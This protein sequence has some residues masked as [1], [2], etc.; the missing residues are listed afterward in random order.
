M[1]PDR[2]TVSRFVGA[3]IIALVPAAGL[4][5]AAPEPQPPSSDEVRP[6]D[7]A[8]RELVEQL[9]ADTRQARQQASEK[10]LAAGSRAIHPLVAALPRASAETTLRGLAILKK[11]LQS[12]D[13][14]TKGKA[15]VALEQL[16]RS[17]ERS[18]AT[19]AASILKAQDPLTRS[20]IRPPGQV[21]GIPGAFRMFQVQM[22]N[23]PATRGV[24]AR[25]NRQ[26]VVIA[27]SR[28]KGISVTVSE[29]VNGKE[30]TTTVVAESS[31]ELDR[32]S[33]QAAALYRK[34]MVRAGLG[35]PGGNPLIAP[36]MVI[37]AEPFRKFEMRRTAPPAE[38]P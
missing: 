22:D 29:H 15:R 24:I 12:T 16:A 2:Q 9:D 23:G 37:P 30:Q 13:A 7:G 34:Y 20:A 18:L 28:E 1:Q 35:L 31:E 21:V 14:E 27:E 10:L 38:K 17:D 11:L 5:R 3:L 33:P 4:T 25:V 19:Q 32:K 8:L 26:T 6:E 36:G